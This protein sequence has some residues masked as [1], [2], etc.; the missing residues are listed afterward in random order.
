MIKLKT[1]LTESND[2]VIEKFISLLPKYG[3]EFHSPRDSEHT[4]KWRA[5]IYPTITDKE[6]IVKVGLDRTDI[7]GR[8]GYVWIGDPSRPILNGYVIQ[9]IVTD[10]KER[11][12]G[13]AKEVLRQMIKCADEAGLLL[14]LEPVPMK[15]FIKKG[16]RSLTKPQLQKWYSKYGFK[17]E[18]DANIMTRPP[19]LT[20]NESL[21]AT[22][23]WLEKDGT[24]YNT[25]DTQHGLYVADNHGIFGVSNTLVQRVF[26]NANTDE[27]FDF[28]EASAI[29]C[30][31]AFAKGWLR[32]VKVPWNKKI[33]VEGNEPTKAQRQVLEDWFFEDKNNDVIWQ[34]W[35]SWKFGPPRPIVLFSSEM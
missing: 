26:K 34:R 32:V 33:F 14:K 30:E 22:L 25:N 18:P 35:V 7:F 12:R 17:K 28:D 16:E 31:Q 27:R 15:D 3:L 1:L 11:G 8:N 9:A 6:H 29:M 13:R 5:G 23:I 19:N 10:P 20:E 21:D 2:A 24:V 4:F